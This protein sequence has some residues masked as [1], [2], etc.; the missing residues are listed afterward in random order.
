MPER[1]TEDHRPIKTVCICHDIERGMGHVDA[2][3]AFARRAERT[4]PRDLAAMRQVEAEAGARATYFVVG[5]LLSEVRDAIEGDGHAL[6]F[7][8]FDHR[9]GRDQLQRCREVD[10]R[11]KGY[12]P[13]HS[14][15]TAELTDRNLLFHNFEWLASAPRSLG[16]DSPQMRAGL[17]RLPIA[18]DDFPMYSSRLPYEDWEQLALQRIA[19]S[20]FAAIS[21]HDCYAPYWL[22]RY[23][24]FLEQVQGDRRATDARRGRGRAHP[25]QR[26]LGALGIAR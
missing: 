3:P 6:G 5:S 25:A 18:L 4:S 20:D 9:S 2:D 8:S 7:H 19:E 17:V 11:I 16:T 24:R 1:R 23:R 14:R 10:Y 13:P 22:P 15:I 12:R 26:V 21:L